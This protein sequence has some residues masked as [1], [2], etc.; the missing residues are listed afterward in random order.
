MLAGRQAVVKI[1]L[2]LPTPKT[3]LSVRAAV[4]THPVRLALA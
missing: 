3:E 1:A 4:H 2:H